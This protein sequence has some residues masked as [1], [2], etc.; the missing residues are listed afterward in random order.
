MSAWNGLKSQLVKG[1][2]WLYEFLGRDK[3]LVIYEELNTWDD[4]YQEYFAV[5]RAWDYGCFNSQR[6]RDISVE[7]LKAICMRM[8]DLLVGKNYD[9]RYLEGYIL[10]NLLYMVEWDLGESIHFCPGQIVTKHEIKPTPIQTE[11]EEVEQLFAL[12][13]WL[14][15]KKEIRG[16]Y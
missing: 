16:P 15:S 4:V 1:L 14:G 5:E 3:A 6:V 13:A 11:D 12:A 7:R 2:Y 10:N 9:W 8:F